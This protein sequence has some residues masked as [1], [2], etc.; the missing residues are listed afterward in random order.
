M[1]NRS[2]IF[3]IESLEDRTVP[4]QAGLNPGFSLPDTTKPGIST[5]H[6]HHIAVDL[7]QTGP[8]PGGAIGAS[9]DPETRYVQKLYFDLLG[10]TFDTG[11]QG[12][13]DALNNAQASR[14]DVAESIL[15][16]DEYATRQIKGMF[17]GF[18]H[19]AADQESLSAYVK[20]VVD[21][22]KSFED[23]AVELLDSAEYHTLHQG[24]SQYVNALFDDVL[25]RRPDSTSANLYTNRVDADPEG[26]AEEIVT[27]YESR[28][29]GGAAAVELMLNQKPTASLGTNFVADAQGG[30]PIVDVLADLAES[31]AYFNLTEV[32]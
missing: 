28:Q 5:G 30:K 32:R 14:R 21:G 13:I 1:T 16:S 8:N 23:I 3:A 17:D 15:K 2:R 18:L 26:V 27:S 9:G 19:R 4:A 12:Y 7:P 10:R 11:A 6:V 29:L 31:E 20:S 25:G 22:D 24:S